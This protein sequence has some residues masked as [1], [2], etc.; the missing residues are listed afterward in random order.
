MKTEKINRNSPCP[1]GSGKKYKQ[2]CLAT[3]MSSTIKKN[4]NET[5]PKLFM[6]ACKAQQALSLQDA[7]E[8]YRQILDI[9][10]KHANSLHNLGL[11]MIELSK[12]EEAIVLLRK[13]LAYE[14]SAQTYSTLA[15]A[16]ASAKK[17]TEAINSLKAA[18]LLN[19]GDYNIYSNIGLLLSEQN[20]Y[21][22][23]IPYLTKA[24][25][26]NP[27]QES[28]F[29][30][31]GL[32]Q[33]KQGH[34]KEAAKLFKYAINL[35]SNIHQNY[36]NL[37]FALCFDSQAFPKE[38][39]NE[40]QIFDK[41]LQ[42][43][44]VAYSHWNTKKDN[45]PVRL[46]FVSGDL[47]NHPVGYFLEGVIQQL[48]TQN[49][50]CYAYNTVHYEDDLTTRIKPCFSRW[51]NITNDTDKQ[52]AQIIYNDQIDILI[53][54]S[55]HTA[56]SRLPLFVYKPAPIQVS[57]LGYF[58][59]TGLQ[60]IDYFLADSES[61]PPEYHHH[62]IEKIWYLP[63]TRLCFT[64]PEIDLDVS[65][66]PY[67]KNKFVTF[68]C[69]QNQSKINENTIILWA[70]ILNS[71]PNSKLMIKNHQLKDD[72]VKN[73][74]LVS[75]KNLGINDTRIVIEEGGTRSSYFS[76]YHKVDIMLDTFPYPG[77]TTTCEALWMGVPTITLTGRTL[78]ERQGAS[79]LRC[80]NLNDWV[81]NTK[82]E[83]LEKAIHH[84]LN[85]EKL[86]L[87]RQKLRTTLQKSPLMDT[88]QF[89]TNLID[90][91][92]SMCQLHKKY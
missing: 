91:L 90:A 58:A 48:H 17:P 44:Y 53:D 25:S 18:L 32:C 41:M 87:L 16:L 8:L 3:T 75:F 42:K 40:A 27:K 66:S 86:N 46:G 61:V 19:P 70:K 11:L 52:A 6:Q 4:L 24:I 12:V 88:I 33:L 21:E 62:F 72:F 20:Q 51:V 23:A 73:S 60:C 13:S 55:G 10:P 45:C 9:N 7:E 30:N 15:L 39:L 69:F 56:N 76:A 1:C 29:A 14:P 35:N 5:I 81:A 34:Y 49:I 80:V 59:S 77:G 31:L 92:Y 67:L 28:A 74:L 84:T 83:Y 79:I 64:R 50:E 71:C 65:T 43:K 54:L 85:I 36:H 63:D 26:L 89:T 68:G 82:E 22:H 78:L 47:Y 2:C 57:W 38:Y 37:L